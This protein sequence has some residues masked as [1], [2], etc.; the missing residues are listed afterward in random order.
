MTKFAIIDVKAVSEPSAKRQEAMPVSLRA[1]K[2]FAF[3]TF[4]LVLLVVLTASA[5]G[6]VAH[7]IREPG[8]PF[9]IP[10]DAGLSHELAGIAGLAPRPPYVPRGE[11][12]CEVKMET[13]NGEPHLVLSN[14]TDQTREVSYVVEFYDS[15]KKRWYTKL[16]GTTKMEKRRGFSE[17]LTFGRD[18]SDW[19]V[20]QTSESVIK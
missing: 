6:V 18:D 4:G 2:A 5:M 13:R 15:A 9:Q 7:Q 8:Q 3:G 10:N 1:A 16:T 20:R 14:P 19:R 12:R 17:E 11:W